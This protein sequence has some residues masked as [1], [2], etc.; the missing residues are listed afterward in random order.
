MPKCYKCNRNLIEK[1][2]YE[3]N[4]TSFPEKPALNHKEHI[5]QN[6]LHGKLK[7]DSILCEDCGGIL[8]VE[9]DA[10]FC[11]L[12]EVLTEQ[13]KN[14]L[15]SKDHG[16]SY[17]A[18]ILKGYL[19]KDNSLNEKIEIN[20]M[21][22]KVS[23]E[24]PYYEFD[25]ENKL[26]KIYA[27]K[28]RAKQFQALVLK[29]LQ[30]EGD[31]KENV[32]IEIITDIEEE[33]YL[34]LFFSEGITAFNEK[35]RK[36][37][38]KIAIGF[39][40]HNGIKREELKSV[41][42]IR[43]DQTADINYSNVLIPFFPLSAFDT[44]FEM[45]R[46]SI[47][48][49]YPTHEIILFTQNYTNGSKKLFCY[50]SLFSTF[51]YYV[52][53]NDNYKG[54]D[55][56]NT[57]Y[58]TIL[59]QEIPDLNIK[60]IRPKYLN[61]VVDDF[62]IDTSKYNG[63]TISDYIAFIESEYKKLRPQYQLNLFDE[64]MHS[65]SILTT[66]FALSKKGKKDDLNKYPYSETIKSFSN[67]HKKQILAFLNEIKAINEEDFSYYKRSFLEDNGYGQ[68]ERLSYP[69]ELI[70]EMNKRDDIFKAYGRMKF[71]QMTKFI[72]Q[73]NPKMA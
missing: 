11:S 43:V 25:I 41:L 26:L 61:I 60:H 57:Y 69:D 9:I 23:P 52:L 47:E 13:L 72:E 17:K 10:D 6:G 42:K 38:V 27:N 7:A 30:L 20:Y 48:Q 39:A 63:K 53:L 45:N 55:V 70:K 1:E 50:I 4:L 28:S 2:Y 49:K 56:F 64:L 59:K 33:G 71:Q 36:G 21:D 51:Q 5:I 62:G 40:L 3:Q 19:Y 16:K 46:L 31:N 29:K 18:K 12:F 24:N 14:N 68:L 32:T 67:I 44:Y 34:G 37:F 8:S 22:R 73:N 58:Q 66:C 35:F 15:V 65:A 54:V